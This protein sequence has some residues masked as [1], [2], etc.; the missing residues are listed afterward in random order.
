MI[1]SKIELTKT[2]NCSVVERKG[3]HS[4]GG[5]Y[6]LVF[7]C[8]TLPPTADVHVYLYVY[9]YTYRALAVVKGLDL[10]HWIF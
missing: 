10:L 9:V 1:I 3:L 2:T 7:I 8:C 5:M 4:E 6:K